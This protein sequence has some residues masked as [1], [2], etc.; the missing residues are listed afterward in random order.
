MATEHELNLRVQR[1][2]PVLA[3]EYGMIDNY[4]IVYQQMPHNWG[5]YSDDLPGCIA[6]GR[7]RQ[8]IERV[9]REAIAFHLED[10]DDAGEAAPDS[11]G[12]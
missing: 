11:S 9:M 10:D 2:T 1:D 3:T 8:D 4:H 12:H 6:T 7:D 5:A